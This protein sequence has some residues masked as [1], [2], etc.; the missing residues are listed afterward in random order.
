M[1]RSASQ[2][3]R[4]TAVAGASTGLSRRGHELARVLSRCS[5]GVTVIYVTSRNGHELATAGLSTVCTCENALISCAF[6]TL[7]GFA[8]TRSA[9]VGKR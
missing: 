4:H 1:T 6:R 7:L 8:A 9:N 2:P 3:L 5:G